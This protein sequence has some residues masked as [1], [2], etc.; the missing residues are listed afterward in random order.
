[1][2][3]ST[4]TRRNGHS[5]PASP[6]RTGAASRGCRCRTFV[7][8]G[9]RRAVELEQRA[10]PLSLFRIL[11]LD[12]LELAL[13]ARQRE[14]RRLEEG[15]EAVRAPSKSVASPSVGGT[16]LPRPCRRS[17]CPRAAARIRRRRLPR[18]G[19]FP[20]KS[21]AHRAGHAGPIRWIARVAGVHARRQPRR[22]FV[23]PMGTRPVAPRGEP[24]PPLVGR[25]LVDGAASARISSQSAHSTASQGAAAAAAALN[26]SRRGTSVVGASSKR[27]LQPRIDAVACC[28]AKRL[29]GVRCSVVRSRSPRIARNGARGAWSDGT[30]AADRRLSIEHPEIDA[31]QQG[32]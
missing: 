29:A 12:G 25:R 18:A 16:C 19:W 17:S 14:G 26:A 20:R 1:M 9:T 24:I 11:A 27:S 28:A 10:W 4:R 31:S 22:R 8:G 15:R 5:G 30:H 6:R 7:G 2:W 32:S 13:D 3:K 23:G 21:C